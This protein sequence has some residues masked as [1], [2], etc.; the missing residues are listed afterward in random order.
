MDYLS[1]YAEL[2]VRVGANIQTGQRLVIVGEPEHAALI[3]AVAEAG[4]VAGAAD[5]ECVYVDEHL[6]RLHAIHAPEDI[7]DRTPGLDGDRV[8]RRRRRRARRGDR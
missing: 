1:R 4:W 2:A 3:R 7:L 5:V 6:R 8:P